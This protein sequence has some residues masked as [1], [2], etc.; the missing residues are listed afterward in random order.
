MWVGRSMT[1]TWTN[2]ATEASS[3]VVRSPHVAPAPREETPYPE[4]T[5]VGDKLLHRRVSVTEW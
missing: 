1:I 3:L 2:L 5:A 4:S